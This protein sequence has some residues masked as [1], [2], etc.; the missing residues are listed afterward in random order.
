MTL[1]IT[2]SIATLGSMTL[3]LIM[4][5]RPKRRLSRQD[6]IRIIDQFLSGEG[7]PYDWDDFLTLP[8][9]D[10][11]LDQV[12]RRCANVDWNSRN[13]KESIRQI[14]VEISDDTSSEGSKHPGAHEL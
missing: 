10:N 6:V 4:F 12:R 14:L 13:G 7:G 11:S 5:W 3:L 2:L 1:L 9:S 8:I